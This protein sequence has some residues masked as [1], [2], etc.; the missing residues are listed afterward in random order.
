MYICICICIYVYVYV[1]VYVYMY[2]YGLA[3]IRATMYMYI[4]LLVFLKFLGGFSLSPPVVFSVCT[5]YV[6]V[7][8]LLVV[9]LNTVLCH[10]FCN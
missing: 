8:Q 9:V 6:H 10:W 3:T 4:L 5:V 7:L 2:M 1:Y